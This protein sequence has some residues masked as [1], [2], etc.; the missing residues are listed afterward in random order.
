M[1]YLMEAFRR[2]LE[3]YNHHF[4]LTKT[5]ITSWELQFRG[6]PLDLD[7]GLVTLKYEGQSIEVIERHGKFED[8]VLKPQHLPIFKSSRKDGV[9]ILTATFNKDDYARKINTIDHYL[10][11]YASQTFYKDTLSNRAI[12]VTY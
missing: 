6:L 7:Y 8:K 5:G 3:S 1:D 2:A 11:C 12:Y 10:R 9:N 4:I